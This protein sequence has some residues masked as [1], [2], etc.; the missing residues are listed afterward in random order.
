MSLEINENK[1]KAIKDLEYMAKKLKKK[2]SDLESTPMAE[3]PLDTDVLIKLLSE[4][5]SIKKT[6]IEIIQM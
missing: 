5:R 2:I 1:L 6:I 3:F 4:Y